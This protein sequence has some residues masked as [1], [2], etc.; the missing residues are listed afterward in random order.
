MMFCQVGIEEISLKWESL[1]YQE[2]RLGVISQ[3]VT[4][5]KTPILLQI[6]ALAYLYLI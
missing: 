6:Q 3:N 2:A 5:W 4:F 1:K